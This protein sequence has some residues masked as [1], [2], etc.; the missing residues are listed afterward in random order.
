M[1]ALNVVG[2]VLDLI[3]EKLH[4]RAKEDWAGF[5]WKELQASR[6]FLVSPLQGRV[7]E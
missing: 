1:S 3:L 5:H 6:T 4:V 2:K 7:I